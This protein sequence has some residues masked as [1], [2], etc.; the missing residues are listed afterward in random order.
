MLILYF[1][2]PSVVSEE[3]KII[4]GKPVRAYNGEIIKVKI[5]K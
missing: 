3:P 5:L 1:F 4:D 2:G